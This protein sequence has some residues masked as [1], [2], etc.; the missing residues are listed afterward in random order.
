MY[1]HTNSKTKL[2]SQFHIKLRESNQQELNFPKIII[3]SLNYH[4]II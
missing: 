1:L 4:K 2:S 3:G